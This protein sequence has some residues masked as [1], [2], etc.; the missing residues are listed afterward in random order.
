MIESKNQEGKNNRLKQEKGAVTLGAPLFKL[1]LHLLI[2][3][4]YS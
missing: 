2:N 3:Q 1:Y 4:G